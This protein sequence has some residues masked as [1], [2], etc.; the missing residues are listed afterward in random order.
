MYCP[1][2]RTE[3]RRGFYTCS[4]CDVPLVDE[5][6]PEPPKEPDP[7]YVEYV[8]LLSTGNLADIALIKSVFAGEGITFFFQGENVAHLLSQ[9]SRLMVNKDD[10]DRAKEIITELNLG[11]RFIS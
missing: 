2:C 6:P 7:E 9:P 3:F 1:K 5:L 10:L 4:D 8:R 11:Y